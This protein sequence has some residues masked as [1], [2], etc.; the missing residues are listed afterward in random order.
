MKFRQ[1]A[2]TRHKLHAHL[3]HL[4]TGRLIDC[5]FADNPNAIDKSRLCQNNRPMNPN[6]RVILA[7][8][9]AAIGLPLSAA[10]ITGKWK[11]DFETGIGHLKY[12][13]DL[14]ADGE[15][16]TGKAFRDR[17]G[18]NSEIELTD[19]KLKGDTLSFVETVKFQDQDVRIEYTGKV[20]GDEIKFTRKVA[21]FATTEMIAKREKQSVASVAG[22]WQAEFDTP[23]GKQKYVYDFKVDGDKLTGRA[24]GDIGGAKSDTDITQGK[25]NGTEISFLETVKFQGREVPILYTGQ[26]SDEEIKFTRK[27][28]EVATEQMVAKR[29]KEAK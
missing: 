8:A 20:A 3:R 18:Q 16:V 4:T 28:A 29:L 11:A 22:K 10:D 1:T 15:K 17:D 7:A 25:V 6:P 27:V 24:V 26:V 12:V 13:Y 14:K 23:V 2:Q 5:V 21:D 19:G 9:L